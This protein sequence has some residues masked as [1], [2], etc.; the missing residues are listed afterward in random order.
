MC[1]FSLKAEEEE[2]RLPCTV[3]LCKVAQVSYNKGHLGALENPRSHQKT[4]ENINFHQFKADTSGIF[5][6]LASQC[7]GSDTGKIG[8]Q[9]ELHRPGG[10]L[11]PKGWLIDIYYSCTGEAGQYN[12]GPGT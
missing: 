10:P 2:P 3:C 7:P 6:G 4:S 11:L 1:R 8:D 5:L 9:T 12:Q